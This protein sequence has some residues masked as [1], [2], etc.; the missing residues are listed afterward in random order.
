M[1]PSPR[2]SLAKAGVLMTTLSIPTPQLIR[3]IQAAASRARP[4]AWTYGTAPSLDALRALRLHSCQ[5]R[6]PW[7]LR[8]GP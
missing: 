7:K 6:V 4:S 2:T 5:W 3:Y 1:P 8:Q